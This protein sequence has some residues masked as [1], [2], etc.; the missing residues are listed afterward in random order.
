[1]SKLVLPSLLWRWVPKFSFAGTALPE[2]SSSSASGLVFVWLLGCGYGVVCL[3]V[4]EW[5]PQYGNLW[6]ERDWGTRE[7]G[8]KVL[9]SESLASMSCAVELP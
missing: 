7:T 6:P 1:M 3:C 4:L 2:G 9:L 5:V 8:R